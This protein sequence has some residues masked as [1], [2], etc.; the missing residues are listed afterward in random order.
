VAQ[1]RRGRLHRRVRGVSAAAAVVL[2]AP[3]LRRRS[4][5][6]ASRTARSSAS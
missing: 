2:G 5:P 3:G 4:S 6:A 1:R